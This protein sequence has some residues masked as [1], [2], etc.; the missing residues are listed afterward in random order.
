MLVLHYA[1]TP[2]RFY[3]RPLLEQLI[4]PAFR[5]I[6]AVY[7]APESLHGS[8]AEEDNESFV[9]QMLECVSAAYAVDRSRLVVT[10]Y[11]MGAIGT[12][13]F[14]THYPERFA[15]AVPVAGFPN[16]DLA[17]TVPVHAFHSEL[18][19]LFPMAHLRKQ[20]GLLQGRGCALELTAVDVR[21]H[22]DVHGYRTALGTVPAWLTKVWGSD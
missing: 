13:H 7:V 2:T 19:E 12:W 15:A 9:M 20:L 5:P 14:I 8:W 22:F 4:E 17:C 18:D 6:N 21:G 10:G 1:G 11:S 3:G 16:H